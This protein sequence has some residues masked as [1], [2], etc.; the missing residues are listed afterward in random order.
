MIVKG[1][2]MGHMHRKKYSSGVTISVRCLMEH[3]IDVRYLYF[4]KGENSKMIVEQQLWNN[5]V[6]ANTRVFS[7]KHPTQ[8]MQSGSKADDAAG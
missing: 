8:M 1:L 5:A 3:M 7:T 6:P 2:R 4:N